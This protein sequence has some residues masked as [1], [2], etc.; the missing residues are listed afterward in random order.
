MKLHGQH[1]E[2]SNDIATMKI[3]KAYPLRNGMH[4]SINQKIL[5]RC[6]KQGVKKISVDVGKIGTINIP[7]KWIKE[8][9]KRIEKVFLFPD[10]P[11]VLYELN[12]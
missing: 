4:I 7:L 5:N 2:I 12:I 9:G 3:E 10:N 8:H 11:M 6:W 1:F